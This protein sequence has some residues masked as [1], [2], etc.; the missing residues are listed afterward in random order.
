MG[1]GNKIPEIRFKGF[2]GEWEEEELHQIVDVRSGCDYKHLSSGNIPVYGTGGYMLSVNEALSYDE[3][4]IG[5]GRKGTINKPYVLKAPFWTVD[6][7]F[8]AVP[9]KKNNL[10][11]IY[12]IFQNINERYAHFYD[13]SGEVKQNEVIK[14]IHQTLE[15][16]PM[17][18]WFDEELKETFGVDVFQHDFDKTKGYAII[19]EKNVEILIYQLEKLKDSFSIMMQ[20]FLSLELKH[21]DN[22]NKS[23]NKPYADA[24]RAVLENLKFDES[25]L[26]RFYTKPITSHFYSDSDIENFIITWGK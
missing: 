26:R 20:E 16:E 8:Y 13:S 5:I 7:L 3:D 21:P 25:Y 12:D 4:A 19:K 10:N 9:D 6:T 22:A 2:G 18:V 23:T 1:G 17:Q 24:Y 14:F 15:T 11:F